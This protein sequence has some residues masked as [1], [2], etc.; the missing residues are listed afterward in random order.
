MIA[1]SFFV[2]VS[3]F[4]DG[5]LINMLL[6]SSAGSYSGALAETGAG[7]P[8]CKKAVL[9]V[10]MGPCQSTTC[11]TVALGSC[12]RFPTEALRSTSGPGFSWSRSGEGPACINPEHTSPY[13]LH[14]DPPAWHFSCPHFLLGS[15]MFLTQR[16]K[17]SS[18]RL[19]LKFPKQQKNTFS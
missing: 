5:F 1:F 15:D 10:P 11:P 8:L 7:W 19:V 6:S 16:K 4:W 9:K 18:L 2:C 17:K 14:R 13:T 12:T 3:L